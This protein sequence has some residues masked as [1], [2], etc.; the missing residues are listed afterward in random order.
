MTTPLLPPARLP[1]VLSRSLQ[2]IVDLTVWLFALG[3]G[4]FIEAFV[5]LRVLQLPIAQ[6][7]LA[8][9][10]RVWLA[11]FCQP[12]ITLPILTL[13]LRW[14]GQNWNSLGLHKPANWIRFLK[15]VVFGFAIMLGA[16]YAIRHLIITPLHLK[17]HGFPALQGN[18]TGFIA[19]M[20][21]AV[22]GVGLNEEL[23][24]RGFLQNSFTQAFGSGTSGRHAAAIVIGLIFGFA[25]LSWGPGGMVYAGLL[26]TLLGGIYI[27]T[28]SNLWVPVILHSLFDVNR[29]IQFF[30][31]GTDLP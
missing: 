10:P 1:S 9:D 11:Q 8:A 16:A 6:I 28:G 14:R 7:R 4:I 20:V 21:Y 19:L 25:H 31:Y 27:W 12:V 29:A 2:T 18:K 5:M 13:A 30:L 22:A 26:G 3:L 17:S 15:H 24:F 23:Q